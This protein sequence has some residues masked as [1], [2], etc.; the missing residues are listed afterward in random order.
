[1]A[2]GDDELAGITR[3]QKLRKAEK[4]KRA[5][6][7]THGEAD[8]CGFAGGV[9]YGGYIGC[10]IQGLVSGIPSSSQGIKFSGSPITGKTSLDRSM[11]HML[12]TLEFPHLEND[13]VA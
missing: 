13:S 10:G 3:L 4:L 6:L 8:D 7:E 11:H 1:M 2:A 5:G 9:G 12:G